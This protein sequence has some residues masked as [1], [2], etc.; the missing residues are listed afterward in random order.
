[1]QCH[2]DPPHPHPDCLTVRAQLNNSLRCCRQVDTLG[3]CGYF[4]TPRFVCF[5]GNKRARKACGAWT[6]LSQA[7]MKFFPDTCGCFA[8]NAARGRLWHPEGLKLRAWT[9]IN[10]PWV[11]DVEGAHPLTHSLHAC[12][13]A[14]LSSMH[15]ICPP[16]SLLCL[17]GSVFS[18]C[19]CVSVCVFLHSSPVWRLCFTPLLQ[20][21]GA[22]ATGRRRNG[23][24]RLLYEF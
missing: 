6:C 2:V 19:V 9:E 21:G 24:Q 20:L 16:R 13:C 7:R 10:Q 4:K 8:R 22:T 15:C 18:V 5:L 3:M 14:V 23:L 12:I 11:V 17:S 1:M